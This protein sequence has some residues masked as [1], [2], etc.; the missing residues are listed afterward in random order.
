MYIY[1]YKKNDS[2]KNSHITAEDPHEPISTKFG[3]AGRLEDLVTRDN[4]LTIGL[5]VL[6]LW[7]VVFCNFL[8]SRWSPL[9]QCWCYCTVCD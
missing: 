8:I 4:F 3:T 5:G 7:V 6:I 9:I 2:Q 1:I